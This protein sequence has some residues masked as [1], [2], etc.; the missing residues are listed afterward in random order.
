[1]LTKVVIFSCFLAV[2]LSAPTDE[3]AME[4]RDG[5]QLLLG[6]LGAGLYHH[7]LPHAT[8]VVEPAPVA[9]APN[10]KLETEDLVTQVCTPAPRHVCETKT[11]TAQHVE[12]EKVCKEVTSKHCAAAPVAPAVVA[13]AV[14]GHYLGKRDADADPQ[15]PLGLYGHGLGLGLPAAIAPAP[16]AHPVAAAYHIGATHEETHTTPCHEVVAEHC[17]NNPVV[18][19]TPVDI[20]QCHVVQEVACVDEV[21]KIPKTVCEP[22]ETTIV[23]HTVNPFAYHHGWGK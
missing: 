4:D 18:V 21:Q 14:A 17:V 5:K 9:L 15:V 10:C 23:R 16:I 19:D 13:P 1:M 8:A 3:A 2:S 11:V 22:V 20:E 6:G 7:G 12:Y